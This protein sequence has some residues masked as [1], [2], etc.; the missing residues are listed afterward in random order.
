MLIRRPAAEVYEAFVD[1]AITTRFWFTSGSGRLDQDD[2]VL[3]EWDMYG[4]SAN[5]T[6]MILEPGR[7]IVIEW[8]GQSGRNTVEW[9]FDSHGDD[10]TFV[11]I[12]ES[13]FTGDGDTLIEQVASSMG[14]FSLVL[15]GAKAWLEHGLRL[16]LIADRFPERVEH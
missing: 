5:V 9:R 14:G 10:A 4:V 13:G 11:R 7:R 2:E 1:P 16:N 3:W 15:A 12:I 6:T 8:P